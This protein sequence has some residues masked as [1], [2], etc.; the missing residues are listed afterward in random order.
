MKKIVNNLKFRLLAG[1]CC[2]LFFVFYGFGYFLISSLKDSYIQSIETSLVTAI[3]DI[4][5]D[6]KDNKSTIK[7]TLNDI[8]DEFGIYPFYG[9]IASWNMKSQTME[10]FELSEDL[11]HESLFLNHTLLEE[12][13]KAHEGVAFTTLHVP[14][15][16]EEKLKIG[17]V[18]LEK[19]EG[20]FIVLSCGTTYKSHTPY[21]RQMT[22]RLWFGLGI[23]LVIILFLVYGI[24]SHSFSSVQHVI[25]EAR[26]IKADDIGKQITKTHISAEIDNLIDTFNELIFELQHAY[27]QVKQFGQN[28]SHELKTP[29]TIIRGEIEVGLKK[30][31]EKEEYQFILHSIHK[32]ITSLQEIIEKILFLSSVNKKV[33]EVCF[34]SIYVDEIVQ[35]AIE[36][37]QGIAKGSGIVLHVKTFDALTTRGNAPLLKMAIGNLLDNAIK[38]SPSHTTVTIALIGKTL[39]IE[40]EGIGIDP[41]EIPH[42]FERFYRGKR[43]DSI[44][45]SGLGLSIVEAILN[46]HS[47]Q[48]DI[49][50][51]INEV[52]TV[53]VFF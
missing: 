3:K 34:D 52:T 17:H 6:Y 43:V 2:F 29:L 30:E 11:K 28:A 5:H 45:G 24:L 18:I 12:L 48:I 39:S 10:V 9:Q 44:L 47:F 33:Q 42:I 4:K 25:D 14:S 7:E 19:Q 27:T 13:A 36:E 15:L 20:S 40:N 21:V 32:E 8:K 23:L 51:R 37:R 1:L 41:D 53:K 46:L 50:S 31:R 22:V 26:G 16:A 38:Y 49:K 35:E